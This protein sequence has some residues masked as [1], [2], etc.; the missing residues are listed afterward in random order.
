MSEIVIIA[1]C[2]QQKKRTEGKCVMMHTIKATTGEGRLNAWTKLVQSSD[3]ETPA[4]EMYLGQYWSV[5][6][7]IIIALGQKG[8][9]HQLLIAS[10]GLGLLSH[11]DKIPNYAATFQ[12][13]ATDDI[14]SPLTLPLKRRGIVRNWWKQ[15]NQNL[16][17]KKRL[18]FLNQ[19]ITSETRTVVCLLSSLYLEALKGE[20][21]SIQKL[22]PDIQFL[23]FT[24]DKDPARRN[25]KGWIPI[26][27]DLLQK[28]GGSRVSLSAR[29]ALEY[30]RSKRST[31]SI[32]TSDCRSF[33]QK[34]CQQHGSKITF[35]RKPATDD[36][37]KKFI[38]KEIENGAT[39]YSPT[40]RAFR[41]AGF[42]CEM[43]RFRGLFKEV[44]N[45][46]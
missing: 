13:G 45:H 43:K 7:E 37:A 14:C 17:A 23:I 28:L 30:L 40:L 9:R 20:I 15:I 4:D 3:W 44:T 34:R 32:T 8:A 18:T 42:A 19:A 41:D 27:S 33:F 36:Q 12:S 26:E 2:S 25:L 46:A 29:M 38:I 16:S 22:R 10:A 35:D 11:D 24:T 6:R 31:A 39:S 21:Q 1:S 5:I